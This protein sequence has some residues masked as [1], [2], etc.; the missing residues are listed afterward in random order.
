[1]AKPA[2][3]FKCKCVYVE[4]SSTTTAVIRKNRLTEL[5][6]TRQCVERQSIV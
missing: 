4:L 2:D 1:M 3:Y 5:I 6:W